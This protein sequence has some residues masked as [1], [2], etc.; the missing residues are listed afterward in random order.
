ML[1]CRGSLLHKGGT[2]G[3]TL[4]DIIRDVK[5]KYPVSKMTTSSE[6]N[7]DFQKSEKCVVCWEMLVKFLSIFSP[8]VLLT[9]RY[10]KRRSL[11][12]ALQV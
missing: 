6:Y 8:N 7:M 1:G 12:G 4:V 11:Y 2:S 9:G 5:R 10:D 3:H